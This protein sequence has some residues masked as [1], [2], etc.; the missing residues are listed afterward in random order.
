MRRLYFAHVVMF[1][2][3]YVAF[4]AYFTHFNG[5]NTK[6]DPLISSITPTIAALY[7]TPQT[8]YMPTAAPTG[9]NAMPAVVSSRVSMEHDTLPSLP[10]PQAESLNDLPTGATFVT[11]HASSQRVFASLDRAVRSDELAENRMSAIGSLR[12]L[13]ASGDPDGQI[14]EALRAASVDG[15]SVV[16]SRAQAALAE[17]QAIEAAR[18]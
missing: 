9:S 13:A 10:Q 15:D 16:A 14:H 7:P 2:C 8:T 3:S 11:D 5:A 17:L 18:R 4:V 1:V 6:H 12:Q